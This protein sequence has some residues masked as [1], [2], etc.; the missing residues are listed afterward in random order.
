MFMLA[1]I[2]LD[3]TVALIVI[4]IFSQRFRISLLNFLARLEARAYDLKVKKHSLDELDIYYLD[5][6]DSGTNKP[7]IVM[8]HGFTATKELWA[9]FAKHLVKDFRIIAPD[10]AGHGQTEYNPSF[11]YSIPA[12]CERLKKLLDDLNIEQ[13]HITGNSMGGFIAANFAK[14][15]PAAVLSVGLQDP[16]GVTTPQQS[17]MEIMLAQGRN[18]FEVHS[19]AEFKQ[20]YKMTTVKQNI[21]PP[22]L[23]RVMAE[24][25]I[26]RREEF[27][28]IFSDFYNRDLLDSSLAEIT[29]PTQ[30]QWGDKDQLINVSGVDAW[31]AGIPTIDAKVWPAVGHMP[32]VEIPA[33]SANYYK[34][35]LIDIANK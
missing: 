32:Y 18:P 8:V 9:R 5:S 14:T 22:F 19:K 1:F 25:Y 10:L 23:L 31:R 12:Q 6:G 30:L 11:D 35:F 28:N 2:V 21:L 26:Q 27:M 33:E 34:E 16:A 4:F 13:A 29:V 20:F 24:I 7:V 15:Y 17:E 3:I